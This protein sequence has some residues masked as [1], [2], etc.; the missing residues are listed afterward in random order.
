MLRRA[1]VNGWLYAVRAP[2]AFLLMH[3]L[4]GWCPP[5]VAL[6]RLGFRTR[7]EIDAERSALEQ[8]LRRTAA[9]RAS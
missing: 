8:F 5:V 1:G 6:R 4:I 7:A 2:F 3:A 9:E